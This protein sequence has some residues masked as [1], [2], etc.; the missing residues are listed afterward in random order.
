MR[1]GISAVLFNHVS[2][3]F[4]TVPDPKQKLKKYLLNDLMSTTVYGSHFN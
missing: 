1:A 2:S 4:R 3:A